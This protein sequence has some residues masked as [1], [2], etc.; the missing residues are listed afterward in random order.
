MLNQVL[1]TPQYQKAV[2]NVR[3][4]DEKQKSEVKKTQKCG[5]QNRVYL[6]PYHELKLCGKD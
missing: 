2:C 1:G 6:V 3:Y 5:T 4:Y